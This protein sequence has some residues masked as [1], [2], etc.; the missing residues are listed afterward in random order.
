MNSALFVVVA[1]LALHSA[2]GCKLIID[3]IYGFTDAISANK[4][5]STG[6]WTTT[7]TKD[8][9]NP[10]FEVYTRGEDI[11]KGQL[12]DFEK[13]GIE[14]MLALIITMAF[15]ERIC[16]LMKGDW[17]A[18]SQRE[19]SDDICETLLKNTSEEQISLGVDINEGDE[20][21]AAINLMVRSAKWNPRSRG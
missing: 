16:E 21:I 20:N 9:I 8:L 14:G 17:K 15:E 5:T 11:A 10:K 2:F 3:S 18:N 12:C 6:E 19:I 7:L 4:D 1:A 13:E